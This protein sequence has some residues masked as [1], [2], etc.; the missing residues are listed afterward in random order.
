MFIYLDNFSNLLFELSTHIIEYCKKIRVRFIF[1]KLNV[2]YF[3]LRVT[4]VCPAQVS[5]LLFTAAEDGGR[6]G[7]QEVT[8]L[9][10][11][12]S[13]G[14]AQW[15]LYTPIITSVSPYCCS[16]Q[17]FCL[18]FARFLHARH[19]DFYFR[20]L[21]N[22][23]SAYYIA[24]T[25]TDSW[26]FLAFYFCSVRCEDVLGIKLFQKLIITNPSLL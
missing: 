1:Q 11:L 21:D 17:K 12:I 2:I 13:P 3:Q 24:A 14:T 15:P 5:P 20:T 8:R 10:W 16:L 22:F 23:L 18:Q 25:L 6:R 9:T 26:M 7:W 19:F 4:V